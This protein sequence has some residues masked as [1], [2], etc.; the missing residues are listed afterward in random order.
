[1]TTTFTDTDITYSHGATHHTRT[2]TCIRCGIEIELRVDFLWHDELTG[3][4]NTNASAFLV[5]AERCAA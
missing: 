1:M 2:Y 5:H 4:T 3:F